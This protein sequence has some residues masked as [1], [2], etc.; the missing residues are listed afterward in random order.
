[1]LARLGAHGTGDAA[2]ALAE[3]RVL[4]GPLSELV[5][6]HG[7]GAPAELQRVLV[8]PGR[9]TDTLPDRA[10]WAFRRAHGEDDAGLVESAVLAVT[11][12]RWQKVGRRLLEGL[13]E[14]GV[15]HS[16]HAA[17]LSTLL[18]ESDVVPVTVP[19]SWLV[20]YYVQQ[21]GDGYGRL[22]PAKTYTLTR[23]LTPQVR[24]WAAARHVGSR[25]DIVGALAHAL[26]M[27]SR[28]GAAA[29]LGLV[30]GSDGLD[31]T[32]ALELLELAADWPA[33]AVRLAA[34][35]RLLSRGSSGEALDRAARD[36]AASIRRWASRNRQIS[37][38]MPHGEVPRD[39]DAGVRDRASAPAVPAPVQQS[40]LS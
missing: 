9:R 19:G 5:A 3:A 11:N 29:L 32:E 16:G 2:G 34:L 28:H 22:D 39:G 8:V 7:A 6:L 31:D 26:R 38:V 1:M 12:P 18:L 36:R 13:A 14:D 20:R 4:D 21:R 15:L 24:R 33:P 37:L 23:H 27:D 17:V 40:L 25:E 30:D 10:C 35:Q